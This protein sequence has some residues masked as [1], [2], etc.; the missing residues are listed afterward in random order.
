MKKILI[1]DDETEIRMIFQEI[2]EEEG[3]E[4]KTAGN[5]IDGL[6]LLKQ[7]AFD[8][9]ILDK[10]MPLSDGP[11]FIKEVQ[12]TIPSAKILLIS[13]SPSATEDLKVNGFLTKPC[14]VEQLVNSVKTLLAQ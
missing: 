11:T 3:F 14:D 10:K 13:G 8:L 4:V 6:T 12:K 2:L 1:V 5:G 9:I 7:E